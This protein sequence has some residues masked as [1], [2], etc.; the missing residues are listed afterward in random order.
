M[1]N[2]LYHH[3]AAVF[4]IITA[5]LRFLELRGLIAAKVRARTL[6]ELAGLADHLR[7]AFDDFDGDAA[8]RQACAGWCRDEGKE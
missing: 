1:M 2:Q 8:P 7:R 6:A 3:V 5:W 4:E